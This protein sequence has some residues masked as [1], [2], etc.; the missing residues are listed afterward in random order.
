MAPYAHQV[1]DH[2]GAVYLDSKHRII[3]ERE[4]YVG[5]VEI[6]PSEADDSFVRLMRVRAHLDSMK[7][8]PFDDP[9]ERCFDPLP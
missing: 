4:I 2:L 6:L 3:R 9:E 7:R 8:Q 1:Q 5:S